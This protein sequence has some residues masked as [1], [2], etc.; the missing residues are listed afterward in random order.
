MGDL[1]SFAFVGLKPRVSKECLGT[2]VTLECQIS[3][4]TR[5]YPNLRSAVDENERVLL[6]VDLSGRAN[7]SQKC[8]SIFTWLLHP[9]VSPCLS[10]AC[11]LHSNTSSLRGFA[12]SRL[13][14]C[15][16]TFN[17][18]STAPVTATCGLHASLCHNPSQSL[19]IHVATE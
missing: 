7:A 17:L 10:L 5:V 16:S 3:Q 11:L 4:R 9:Q 14:S 8:L 12:L 6:I 18:P 2:E 15:E 19:R 1:V 13:H